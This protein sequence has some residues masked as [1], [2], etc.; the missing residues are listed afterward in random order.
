MPRDK[1]E[2]RRRILTSAEEEFRECGFEKA[3]MRR[4]ARKAGVTAGALYRHFATKE[5]MFAALVEPMLEK[6]YRRQREMMAA[7]IAEAEQGHLSSF[8]HISEEGA[9]ET[10]GFFYDHF[11]EFF[12]LF[13]RSAG[14][15]YEDLRRALVREEVEGTKRLIVVL[16]RAGVPV[17]E[18]TDDQLNVLYGTVFA[19]LFEVMERGFSRE[20]AES[21]AEILSDAMNFGWQKIFSPEE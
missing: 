14:T 4:I 9:L 20:R 6:F 18:F 12:L 5:E 2:T 13:H 17:R 15:R 10:L 16:R 7:A 19:P 21:C 1:T 11:D 8:R 3:S